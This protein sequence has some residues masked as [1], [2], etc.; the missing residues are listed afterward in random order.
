VKFLTAIG[1]LFC[2]HGYAQ[3]ADSALHL[4]MAGEEKEAFIQDAKVHGLEVKE[5]STLRILMAYTKGFMIARPLE[6]TGTAYYSL[7]QVVSTT[8][9][10]YRNIILKNAT[11]VAGKNNSWTDNRYVYI[12]V[13]M[14]DPASHQLWYK[15]MMYRIKN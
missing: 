2:A 1:L 7:A 11:P 9:R 13:D 8:D 4:R 6:D 15:V 3:V 10:D 12:E 5:D 14:E